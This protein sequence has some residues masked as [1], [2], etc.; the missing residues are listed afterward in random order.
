MP[1]SGTWPAVETETQ[2]ECVCIYA[3]MIYIFFEDIFWMDHVQY[4]L[5]GEY[6]YLNLLLHIFK[7]G[8]K[9]KPPQPK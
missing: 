4:I 6:V 7:W 8:P 5:V 9:T 1:T 2:S 3:Y